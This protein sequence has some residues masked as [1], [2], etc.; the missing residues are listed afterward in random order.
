MAPPVRSWLSAATA[1]AL[2]TLSGSA[3]AQSSAVVSSVATTTASIAAAETTV[4]ASDSDAGIDYFTSETV[5]ITD[6]VVDNI[7]TVV[8][9]TIAD[10]FAFADNETL[11]AR[12]TASCK[13]APSDAAWPSTL[14]WNIFDLLL[15]GRLIKTVPS[16]AVCYKS[17]PQYNAAKC[18][19][20]LDQ[21]TNSTLQY[22]HCIT[23]IVCSSS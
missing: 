1:V 16:A 4:A 13:V 15:G 22:V 23:R 10:L 14:V 11:S 5:Q 20:V 18:A 12:S 8:N 6:A 17:W 19:T 2:L 21:W 3:A 9:S 7:T